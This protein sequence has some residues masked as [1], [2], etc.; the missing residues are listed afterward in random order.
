MMMIQASFDE[1]ESMN[2]EPKKQKKKNKKKKNKNK[3][4]KRQKVEIPLL[5]ALYNLMSVASIFPYV[6]IAHCRLL[7]TPSVALGE[8]PK[9]SWDCELKGKETQLEIFS[10]Q[11]IGEL[12][13][14]DE[15]FWKQGS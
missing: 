7:R 13:W 10:F 15:P 1:G 11:K 5:Q 6:E 8:N 9:R 14:K 3:K 2:S 4:N 12:T